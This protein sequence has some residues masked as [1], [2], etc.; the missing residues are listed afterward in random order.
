VG[1]NQLPIGGAQLQAIAAVTALLVHI[2][3]HPLPLGLER[4]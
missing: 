4:A 1:G 2:G 3:G